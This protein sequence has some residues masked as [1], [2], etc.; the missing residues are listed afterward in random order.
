MRQ[1]SILSSLHILA[2]LIFLEI[3]TDTIPIWQIRK[4]M[5]KVLDLGLCKW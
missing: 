3:D 1:N 5:H 4:T 2:H